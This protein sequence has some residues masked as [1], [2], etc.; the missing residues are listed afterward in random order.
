MS[1]LVLTRRDGAV[2]TI[3]LNRPERLNA[4]NLAMWRALG[5]PSNADEPQIEPEPPTAFVLVDQD[6]HALAFERYVITLSD[7]TQRAGMLDRDGKL[8]LELR[9][10]GSIAFPDLGPVR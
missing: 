10:S 9:Q 8:S 6:G 5:D 3:L 2:A 1:D 7:G 4:L